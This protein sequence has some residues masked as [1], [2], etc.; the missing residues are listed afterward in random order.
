MNRIMRNIAAVLLAA[1]F[2]G[3]TVYAAGSMAVVET[4]TGESDITLYVKGVEEDI[5]DATVQVGTVACE[6]VTKSKLAEKKQPMKT[7][8][9]LDNSLSIP[10]KSHGQISEILQNIISDR[11]DNEE[12]SIA[13][14]DEKVV[15]LADYTSDYTT[16]KAAVDGITYQD[17]ETYLTDVLYDLLSTE[18]IP[19]KEDAYRRIIV[20]SDGVDNKSIGYT[21]DELYALL[22]EYPIPIYTIG[23]QTGRN[24]EEL[25]NMFAISR[26]S[27]ADS[28]LLEDTENLLDI[29]TALNA[30]RNI[31]KFRIR[32]T[33]D[34]MDG[35][36]KTVRITLPS[37]TSLS[38]EVVMP[39]QEEVKE[40]VVE[41]VVEE[42]EPE[43]EEEPIEEIPE[44][45]TNTKLMIIIILASCFAIVLAAIVVVV[46][47]IVKK[48]KKSSF[49][50]ITD[51]ILDQ[52]NRIKPSDDEK[53]ELVGL[54]RPSDDDSTFMIWN[55]GTSYDVVLTDVHSPTKSFQ[56]PLR[57]SVVIGRKQDACG[58]VIDYDKSV[59]SRHCEI[60]VRDG[61][62][63]ITDLQSSNHTYVNDC[64]VS[65]EIE[66]FSGNILRLGRLE[67]KFEVR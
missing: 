33:S 23:M 9:M 38:A 45:D 54:N 49:E 41:P 60:K 1:L 36:K 13:T 21:K 7:L 50:P 25:E 65:S 34:L 51:D 22:K 64:I 12:I 6:S 10:E 43:V 26:A 56:A 44:E 14:F 35:S 55:S 39:Q 46:I 57:S 29:N 17:L 4:Y 58:I 30:D 24:N 59:S 63:Y 19:A 2:C 67:L 47:V 32:P 52:M 37:G 40:E 3:M 15:C 18:Y 5:T 27:N 66:I 31:V 61:R 62:F 16:L 28:F 11:A 53:T 42:N 20:I 8:I 48:K